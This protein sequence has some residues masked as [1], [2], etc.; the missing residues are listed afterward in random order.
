MRKRTWVAISFLAAATSGVT[1]CSV[2]DSVAPKGAA[3]SAGTAS[4]GGA[5]TGGRASAGGSAGQGVTGTTGGG[6][7]AGAAGEGGSSGNA[8]AADAGP[9]EGQSD[10]NGPDAPSDVGGEV[11]ACAPETNV[12]FCARN[13]KNCGGQFSAVD[14]CGVARTSSCGLAACPAGLCGSGGTL[15]VCPGDGPVNRA[16]GGTVDSSN[17]S[18]PPAFAAEDMF[19][20]FDNSIMTKW[21]VNG[22]PDV[23]WISYQFPGGTTFAI[24]SYTITSGNDAPERDPRAWELQ[25]TTNGID[26]DTLDTRSDQ[27]FELRFQTNTYYIT[28]IKPYLEYRLNVLD[29]FPNSAIQLSEIQLFGDPG[30]TLEAGLGTADAALDRAVDATGQ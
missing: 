23:T 30:P 1:A 16:Q 11:E 4:T 25:G 27:T 9:D 18:S 28:N 21:Y 6:G 13:R 15:N 3:G 29:P 19:K 2:D 10:A 14:N 20:A 8:G 5:G 12:V 22:H 7:S 24:T 17:P 26:W